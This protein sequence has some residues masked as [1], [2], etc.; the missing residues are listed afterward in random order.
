[1][2]KYSINA[3]KNLIHILCLFK[4]FYISLK[5]KIKKLSKFTNFSKQYKLVKFHY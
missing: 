3:V 1:M 5:K 4:S 2:Y